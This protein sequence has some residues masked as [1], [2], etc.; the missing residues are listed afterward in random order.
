VCSLVEYRGRVIPLTD[1]IKAEVLQ[2]VEKLYEDGMRVLAV[3]QKNDVPP[4]GVFGVKDE[5]NMVLMG[6]LAFLDPPKETAPEAVQALK[7]CGVDVKIL[8]GDNHIVA[9]K[10]CKEVGIDVKNVLLGD[11]I[12]SMSD[13]ELA[14]V[15]EKTTIF[16]K[17]TPTQKARIIKVLRSRGHTVGFLGDG[18]NDTPAMKEADVAIS[19]DNAVD[20]AKESADVI[21]LEKTLWCLKTVL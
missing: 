2:M 6:F 15:V 7:A 11:Q 21:L 20:I 17:L 1:E 14:K 10:I 19:V 5:S 16:A 13:E 18:I 9:K 4:E 8:T 12:E 3:A